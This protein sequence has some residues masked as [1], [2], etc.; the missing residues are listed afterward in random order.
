[1]TVLLETPREHNQVSAQGNQRPHPLSPPP[2]PLEKGVCWL[3][4]DHLRGGVCVGGGEGVGRWNGPIRFSQ[5]PEGH[6][7]T[8][9]LHQSP[10]CPDVVISQPHPAGLAWGLALACHS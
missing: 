5:L 3:V 2:G 9:P 8:R 6:H 4:T 1:M 10:L 7:T